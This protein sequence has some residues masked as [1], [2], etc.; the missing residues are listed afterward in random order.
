MWRHVL[1]GLEDYKDMLVVPLF[2]SMGMA[3]SRPVK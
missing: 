1:L 2:Y 3:C